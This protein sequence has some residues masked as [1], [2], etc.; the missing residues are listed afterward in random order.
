M[1]DTGKLVL[2][3]IASGN[4]LEEHF[5]RAIWQYTFKALK[6]YISVKEC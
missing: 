3:Y 5:E 4:V 1:E 6:S 2:S